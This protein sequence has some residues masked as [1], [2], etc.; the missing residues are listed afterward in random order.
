M[1]L[2]CVCAGR[3]HAWQSRHLVLADG[4]AYATAL[5]DPPGKCTLMLMLLMLLMLLLL[6]LLLLMLLMLLMLLLLLL[7]LLRITRTCSA[8]RVGR[9]DV[10][11]L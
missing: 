5:G 10:V 9:H 3:G 2:L 1:Y 11:P 7:L 4:C 8:A 6:L